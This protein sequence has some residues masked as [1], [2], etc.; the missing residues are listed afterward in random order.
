MRAHRRLLIAEHA[1]LGPSRTRRIRQATRTGPIGPTALPDD[2]AF[3]AAELAPSSLPGAP[4]T[5]MDLRAPNRRRGDSNNTGSLL[6]HAPGNCVHT[7]TRTPRRRWRCGRRSVFKNQLDSGE[8]HHR[9]SASRTRRARDVGGL[10]EA[11]RIRK[12]LARQAPDNLADQGAYAHRA[13]GL[14]R[15]ARGS[16]EDRRRLGESRAA[17][18]SGANLFQRARILAVLGD[19]E[20]AVRELQ[21]AFAKGN[22]WNGSAMHLDACW[23]ERSALIR[24]LSSGSS[25]RVSQPAG[26]QRPAAPPGYWP[27]R[28]I[29]TVFM[30]TGVT[31]LSFVPVLTLPIF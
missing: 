18:T 24:R 23:Q 28:S 22:A 15:L 4:R 13:R 21:A 16:T 10:P 31:G 12:D 8:A 29:V 19:R 11:V 3:F 9:H 26:H 6:Y 5:S 1:R 30:T 17:V 20:G 7:G 25:R 2:G 27:T 14:R